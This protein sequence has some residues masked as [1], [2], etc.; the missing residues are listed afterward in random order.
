MREDWWAAKI[1]FRELPKVERIIYLTFME[2][3]KRVQ[4]LIALSSA[5]LPLPNWLWRN[6]PELCRDSLRASFGLSWVTICHTILAQ[7]VILA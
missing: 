1:G 6:K 4:N 2:E 3:T 5:F 7:A